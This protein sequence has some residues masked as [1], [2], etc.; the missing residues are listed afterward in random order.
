MVEEKVHCRY[1][2]EYRKSQSQGHCRVQNEDGLTE[3]GHVRREVRREQEEQPT[4]RVGVVP[5]DWL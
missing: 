2:G 5:E 4:K 1:E 3:Q